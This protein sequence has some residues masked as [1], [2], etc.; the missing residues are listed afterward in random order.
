MLQSNSSFLNS[1]WS[2]LLT[3]CQM[4]NRRKKVTITLFFFDFC[5]LL[6]CYLKTGDVEAALEWLNK[7]LKLPTVNTEV[8]KILCGGRGGGA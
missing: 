8:S 1:S 5:H 4:Y 2:A 7:A 3:L 6:Q